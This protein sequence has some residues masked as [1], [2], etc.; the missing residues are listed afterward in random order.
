V[1]GWLLLLWDWLWLEGLLWL[2]LGLILYVRQAW[3]LGWQ[4]SSGLVLWRAP[5]APVSRLPDSFLKC[6][7]VVRLGVPRALRWLGVKS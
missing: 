5:Q 3:L 1:Q 7:H 2:V 6:I 4:L